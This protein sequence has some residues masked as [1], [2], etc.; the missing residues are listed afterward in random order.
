[1][2]E[3]DRQGQP[4]AVRVTLHHQWMKGRSSSPKLPQN[5]ALHVAAMLM[6]NLWIFNNICLGVFNVFIISRA[7]KAVGGSSFEAKADMWSEFNL[8]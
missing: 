8:A 7:V 4:W 5:Y 2:Q 3:I 6:Q 1:M